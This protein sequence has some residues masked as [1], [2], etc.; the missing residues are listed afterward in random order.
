MTCFSV[1]SQLTFPTAKV[2]S[3]FPIEPSNR[4][5][6]FP[7]CC[8]RSPREEL[9]EEVPCL[10]E[11]D[12]H[13]FLQFVHKRKTGAYHIQGFH[14]YVKC[15]STLGNIVPMSCT[16]AHSAITSVP[17]L[18]FLYFFA[19]QSA[20]CDNRSYITSLVNIIFMSYVF[21]HFVF[22]CLFT[23]PSLATG[24]QCCSESSTMTDIGK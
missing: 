5:V 7:S 15:N 18:L 3:R 14:K 9:E 4:T 13:I 22:P 16:I 17:I 12:A 23:I 11:Y 19:A 10:P 24:F 6:S 20:V 8:T 1:H 21:A 2:I